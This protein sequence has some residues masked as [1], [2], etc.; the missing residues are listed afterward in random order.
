MSTLVKS[1]ADGPVGKPDTTLHKGEVVQ[2]QSPLPAAK[3]AGAYALEL[4]AVTEKGER[5]V[6]LVDYVNRQTQ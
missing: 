5:V 3:D 6:E 2:C 1:V 4:T